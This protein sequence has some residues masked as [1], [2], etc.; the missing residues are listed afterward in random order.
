MED[1][2]PLHLNPD[3]RYGR[4]PNL[5]GEDL[6]LMFARCRKSTAS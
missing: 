4:V 1:R 2:R 3:C 5:A 6:N